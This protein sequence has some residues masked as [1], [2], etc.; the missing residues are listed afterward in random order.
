VTD[1]R[2][3]LRRDFVDQD[4][5]T[6]NAVYK[7]DEVYSR[8]RVKNV[9]S[10][11]TGDVMIQEDFKNGIAVNNSAKHS[12]TSDSIA[13]GD[14]SEKNVRVQLNGQHKYT[15]RASASMGDVSVRSNRA[16]LT[17]MQPEL[18]LRVFGPERD[19]LERDVTHRVSVKNT[20][21]DPAIKT[22]VQLNL[23]ESSKMVSTSLARSMENGRVELGRLE[24]GETRTFDVTFRPT[25]VSTIETGVSAGAYC[26]ETQNKR[27]RTSIEGHPAI[28]M[29]VTDTLDPVKIGETTRYMI[30]IKNQG[31]A[32][33]EKVRLRGILPEGTEFVRATGETNVKAEGKKLIFDV[34]NTLEVG[35]SF[36]WEVHVRATKAGSGYFTLKLDSNANSRTVTEEEPTNMVE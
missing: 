21:D 2:I 17:V 26:V 7:C 30:N 33:D 8:Y 19:F 20:S 28:G 25:K 31:T 15:G 11:S 10:G 6:V 24:A 35:Q 18:Q 1:P 4:G 22:F 12:Y 9:G 34:P 32:A 16:D 3:T 23:P 29:E 13:T 14:T 27:I 5:N 36:S